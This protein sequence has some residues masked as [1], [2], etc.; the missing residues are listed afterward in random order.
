MTAKRFHGSKPPKPV[1]Q[2][3]LVL[4]LALA[5]CI[6]AVRSAEH[7]TLFLVMACIALLVGLM[8]LLG[9]KQRSKIEYELREDLLVL[10]RGTTTERLMLTEVL[11]ASLVDRPTARDYLGTHRV[12]TEYCGI[13]VGRGLFRVLLSGLSGFTISEFR[14]HLVLI[15]VR[16]GGAYL[17]SP[18][19]GEHMVSVLGGMLGRQKQVPPLPN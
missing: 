19:H 1:L 6:I 13:P 2:A 15:R 4:A 3:G 14:Q 17:L 12:Q 18:R 5:L 8:A 9:N 11:D 10:R 7:Q 16:G